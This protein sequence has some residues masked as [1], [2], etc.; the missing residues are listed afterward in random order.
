MTKALRIVSANLLNG[1]ATPDAFAALVQRLEADIVN[2]QELAPDQAAA[3]AAVMPFGSLH[4]ARDCTGMGIAARRPVVMRTIPF[5][6]EQAC[7]A[8]VR[9]EDWPELRNPL[10]IINVHFA[11]PHHLPVWRPLRRRRAQLRALDDY[12]NGRA[13]R[14][15]MIIGDFNASPLWPLYRRLAARFIDAAREM[16]GRQGT[17]PQRTWGPWQNAP[18][19][20]RIDHAFISGVRIADFRVVPIRGSDHSALVVDT[21]IA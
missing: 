12:C 16:G 11:A 15:R 18:K 17:T 19:L 8:H 2:V 3:L 21:M 6:G 20:L 7:V 5:P 14:S 10:E 13:E 9:P 4:P 1:C